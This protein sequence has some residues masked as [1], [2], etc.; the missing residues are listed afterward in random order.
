MLM[1]TSQSALNIATSYANNNFI[2]VN[3]YCLGYGCSKIII[4][5]SFRT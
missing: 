5:A 3:E 4:L 2:G 1:I